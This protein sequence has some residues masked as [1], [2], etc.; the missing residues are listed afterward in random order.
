[1]KKEEKQGKETKNIF[2]CKKRNLTKNL[3][4]I[5]SGTIAPSPADSKIETFMWRL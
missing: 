4:L 2:S 1:M 3:R 5:A